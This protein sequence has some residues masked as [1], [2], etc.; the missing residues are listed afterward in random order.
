MGS[1]IRRSVRG[2]LVA[3]VFAA[4]GFVPGAASAD[5]EGCWNYGKIF[6]EPTSECEYVAQ[7]D[8]QYVYV[9][10]PYDWRVW[11]VRYDEFNQ[12]YTVTFASGTGVPAGPP[13]EI[14]PEIGETV[15][16]TMEPG[17]TGPVCG[18]KGFIG[19]GLEQG[20]L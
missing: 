11:T 1:V 3:S 6:L 10:T 19:A 9:G 5:H 14:H 7:T 15:H 17:C 13:P 4:S 8:T 12:P 20:H 16:V 18:T 2:V